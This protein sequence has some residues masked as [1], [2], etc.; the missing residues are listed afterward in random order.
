MTAPLPLAMVADL[1]ATDAEFSSI[2][3]SEAAE[4]LR[5]SDPAHVAVLRSLLLLR[6]RLATRTSELRATTDAI[7]ADLSLARLGLLP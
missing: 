3:A 4:A 5:P 2:V 6:D 1:L 7:E